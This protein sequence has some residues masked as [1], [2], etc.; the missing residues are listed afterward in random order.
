MK[1]IVMI[2]IL[3][4]TFV[5]CTQ[6]SE[7]KPDQAEAPDLVQMVSTQEAVGLDV[8]TPEEIENNPS[9]GAIHI[10]IS[11]VEGRLGEIDKNKTILVFCESGGRASRVEKLLKDKGFTKVQN[12]TDWRTWNKISQNQ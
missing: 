9:P 5:G 2:S 7:E 10:P 12:I 11:E 1:A 8:R 3:L 4:I 6:S